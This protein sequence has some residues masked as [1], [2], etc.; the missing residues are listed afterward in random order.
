[1]SIKKDFYENGQVKTIIYKTVSGKWHREDGPAYQKWFKNGQ[2]DIQIYYKKDKWHR[3]DGPASQKWFKNGQLN[4]QFFYKNAKYHR[5]DGPACI[6]WDENGQEKYRFYY[7]NDKELSKEEF[8]HFE[9]S[10][11]LQ[12]GLNQ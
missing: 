2:L 10:K 7:L 5:E 9:Y 12:R 8:D 4:Y 6:S 11:I 3:E 1:M